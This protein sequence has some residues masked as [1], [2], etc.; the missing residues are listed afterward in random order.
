[1][2]PNELVK[3]YFTKRPS[4]RIENLSNED[5]LKI[6]AVN[7]S[8]LKERTSFDMLCRIEGMNGL[9]MDLQRLIEL[10]GG[11]SSDVMELVEQETPRTVPVNFLRLTKEEP[12]VKLS[13]AQKALLSALQEAGEL[14]SREVHSATVK[15]A[16]AKGWA[17]RF[18]KEITEQGVTEEV[19][20]SRAEA[21]TMG[22][23]FHACVLEP[24]RFHSDAFYKEWQLSPTKS[25]V[26]KEALAALADDPTRKLITSEIVERARRIS[27]AVWQHDE[28]KRILS[29]PGKAEIT[30]EVWEELDPIT[31]IGVMRKIKVDWLPD[32]PDEG[33]LDLK[34]TR[35]DID[36]ES[37][38]TF[39]GGDWRPR[40]IVKK[41]F[42]H[43]QRAFYGDT[44]AMFEKRRR[45]HSR[46]LLATDKPPYKVRVFDLEGTEDQ[47]S[48]ICDGRGLVQERLAKFIMA[49]MDNKWEAYQHEGCVT[50]TN[51][52]TTGV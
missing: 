39:E 43:G 30:F 1:M 24:H 51:G 34:K 41:F 40:S 45:P 52:R 5:Y 48:L 2:T 50:L 23:V 32:S 18:V 37:D 14:D 29:L 21:L 31:K 49:Y 19:K 47:R 17:E 46:I 9:P 15:G 27:E 16:V 26:S 25:L 36:N 35:E 20:A 6:P 38:G 8:L 33:E 11:N 3:P 28:A 13:D 12:P 22:T 4:R 44:L 10:R 42:Y 7:Y